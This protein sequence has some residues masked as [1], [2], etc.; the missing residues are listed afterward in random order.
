MSLVYISLIQPLPY[1]KDITQRSRNVAQHTEVLEGVHGTK[2]N[3]LHSSI[4]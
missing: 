4:Y 3:F 1:L 2:Y